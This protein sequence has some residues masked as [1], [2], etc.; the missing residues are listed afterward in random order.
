MTKLYQNH[1]SGIKNT[2]FTLIELL[3]VVLIIGILAAVALPQYELAVEKA[4]VARVL[5]L[6]RSITQAQE[7]FQLATGN[8]SVDIDEMDISIPYT[9]KGPYASGYH[10]DVPNIGGFT[11][12]A[13]TVVYGSGRGYTID[14]YGKAMEEGTS[15]GAMGICYPSREGTL[16]EKVCRSLGRKLSRISSA[17]T[18]CY[19]I[20]Y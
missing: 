8:S 13:G 1:P 6:F 2:G 5:P 20:D 17:N 11:L 12:Y 10:Y 15:G 18:P 4:R 7:R 16:G 9:K 19:A 14:Y 3:V